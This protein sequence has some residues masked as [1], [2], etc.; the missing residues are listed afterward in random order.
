MRLEVDEADVLA[1]G[2]RR[3]DV[4]Q[5]HVHV[6]PLL[7][8]PDDG[9]LAAGLKMVRHFSTVL[10]LRLFNDWVNVYVSCF[11]VKEDINSLCAAQLCCCRCWGV[12]GTYV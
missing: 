8:H 3:G 6:P 7:L 9:Q 5:E 10:E 1:V 2:G 12:P 11:A 4:G